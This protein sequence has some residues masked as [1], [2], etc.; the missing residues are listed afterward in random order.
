M[1]RRDE[2]D[3]REFLKVTYEDLLSFL[4]ELGPAEYRTKQNY[5]RW[6]EYPLALTLARPRDGMK[7]LEIGSGY[8]NVMPLFLAS[9]FDVRLS[10]ITILGSEES[11]VGLLSREIRFPLR[12]SPFTLT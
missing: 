3:T 12:M 1:K 5:F 2:L 7:I 6:L 10:L 4:K 11:L 8:V 9:R